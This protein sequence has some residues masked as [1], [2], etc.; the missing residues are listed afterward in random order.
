MRRVGLRALLAGVMS[1]GLASTAWAGF[2]N[3]DDLVDINNNMISDKV[4][5]PVVNNTAF[6][7]LEGSTA[8]A[9]GNVN[10]GG[11]LST[12]TTFTGIR[13]FAFEPDQTKRG[14]NGGS[15][16][17]KDQLFVDVRVHGALAFAGIVP[18]CKAKI[19]AKAKK[20]SLVPADVTD[21]NW[22]MNCN[23]KAQDTMALSNDDI[24]ALILDL[25]KK[26]V[27]KNGTVNVKGKCTGTNCND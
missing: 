2:G 16:Q 21:G 6:M 25:G 22:S 26:V 7:E 13:W 15:L 9:S 1:I 20:G 10:N 8:F 19:Q 14:S 3:R 23:N 4:D 27:G 12:A 5:S 17:Q 18:G 11:G 24:A